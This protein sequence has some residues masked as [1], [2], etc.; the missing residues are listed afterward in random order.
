MTGSTPV[1][2]GTGTVAGVVTIGSADGSQV[3][4]LAPGI[5]TAGVHTNGTLSVDLTINQGSQ[6]QFSLS[7]PT[8]TLNPTDTDA[9]KTALANGTYT[10]VSSM[11]ASNIA[12]LHN[13]VPSAG[14][15]DV[16]N[17]TGSGPININADSSTPVFKL[18]DGATPYSTGTPAIGQVFVL[19]DWSF[20]GGMTLTGTNTSLSAANFDFTGLSGL[21]ASSFDFSAFQSQGILVVVPEPSRMLLMMFGLLGLFFRRRRRYSRL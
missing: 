6:V 2:S 18:I 3:G 16:L 21:T 15:H 1:L 8:T 9:L 7:S 14:A 10:N 4:V 12:A 20:T 5:T 13:T 17:V 19:V 11:F